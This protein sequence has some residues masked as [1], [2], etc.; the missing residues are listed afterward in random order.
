MNKTS[1]KAFLK[2]VLITAWDSGILSR[3]NCRNPAEIIAGKGNSYAT[4]SQK[5][6]L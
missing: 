5:I 6:F 4:A 2:G 3:I 1:I